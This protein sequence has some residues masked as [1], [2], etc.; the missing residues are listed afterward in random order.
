MAFEG[1]VWSC[2]ESGTDVGCTHTVS[3]DG[4]PRE[5]ACTH[6]HVLFRSFISSHAACTPFEDNS[7]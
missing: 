7:R 3:N 4:R 1:G 2:N 6:F 5:Q